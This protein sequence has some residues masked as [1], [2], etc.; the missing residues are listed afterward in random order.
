MSVHLLALNRPARVLSGGSCAE[1]NGGVC[2]P[3]LV[4][5]S[6][7]ETVEEVNDSG[8]NGNVPTLQAQLLSD[9]SMLQVGGA[10]GLAGGEGCTEPDAH[11]PSCSLDAVCGHRSPPSGDTALDHTVPL[12]QQH[13][14]PPPPPG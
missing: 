11:Q 3:P 9:D 7:G 1:P 5:R 8:F 10:C 14:P 13:P 12:P 6:I 2:P 4:V